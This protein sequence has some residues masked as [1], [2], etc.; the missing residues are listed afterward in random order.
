MSTVSSSPSRCEP[1]I[2]I[3]RVSRRCHPVATS[4]DGGCLAA[5]QCRLTCPSSSARDRLGLLSR[6][7]PARIL[8]RRPRTRPGTPLRYRDPR[9]GLAGPAWA[10][11]AQRRPRPQPRPAGGGP[12]PAQER[13]L[14][15]ET[16][17]PASREL[18]E[19]RQRSVA[20]GLSHVLPV[21]VTAAG[22]GVL[23]DADG[24]S[25][26]DFGSGIAVTS[27]GN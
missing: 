21:F 14:V 20:R 26:I 16:P 7:G 10:R 13:P 3:A 27:V 19:R 1:S 18:L 12:P 24:N 8:R 2:S 5:R 15:T 6:Y 4:C 17:G 9:A 11:P 25:L 22:G 23:I